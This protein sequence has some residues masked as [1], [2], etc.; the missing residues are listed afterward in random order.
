V[1]FAIDG[2][3]VGSG[4]AFIIGEIAQAHEG[5][6]SLALEFIDAIATAGADAVKFQTHIA[7][8]ESSLDEPFRIAGTW[9]VATRYEYWQLM[10]FSEAEWRTLAA[11]A[12]ER[13]L[14]FLSSPFSVEAVDLLTRVGISAWKIASG[15]LVHSA[16]LER[17]AATGQPVLLSTGLATA[18]EVDRAV[19]LLRRHGAPVAVFQTTTAYPCPPEQVGLNV[20]AELR[21]RYGCPVGLS[22]HSGT[23]FPSLAAVALGADLLEVHVTL[24]RQMTGPDVTS[25]V[26]PDELKQLVTGARFI[27]TMRA[28]P[29]NKTDAIAAAAPLRTLF[30]RSVATLVD[31]PEGAQLLREHLGLRKPGG[32][33]P[34][35]ALDGLVGRRLRRPV[36][37]RTLLREEDL[38]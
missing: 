5:R 22:D 13:G 25:S 34:P 16:L 6:L 7:E 1:T 24:N 33:L 27:E 37:A 4:R 38:A 11:R 2:R 26:T 23:V 36:R 35:A 29:V 32:G 30:T 20:I 12:Q 31:L 3:P 8:A 19:A 15:E 17:I 10:S 28:H 21:A 9:P 18:E 14:V